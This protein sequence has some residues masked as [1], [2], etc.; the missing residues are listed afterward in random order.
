MIF[1]SL[2]FPTRHADYSC[3]NTKSKSE[4]SLRVARSTNTKS[5]TTITCASKKNN[6]LVIFLILVPALQHP[7]S[8]A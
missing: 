1:G 8:G 3:I 6:F 2:F 5:Q 7:F 4:E